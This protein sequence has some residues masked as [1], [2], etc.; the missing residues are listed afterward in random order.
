MKSVKI[1]IEKGIRDR[2]ESK[3]TGNQL[4]PVT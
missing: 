1:R 3:Q 4:E 2:N